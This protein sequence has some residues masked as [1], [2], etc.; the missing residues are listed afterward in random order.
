[1]RAIHERQ[2]TLL[3]GG[4]VAPGY[5]G[6]RTGSR[7]SKQASR[8]MA[9]VFAALFIGFATAATA[10][11][12]RHSGETERHFSAGANL[13]MPASSAAVAVNLW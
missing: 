11:T 3:G 9:V 8:R 1:M 7:I 4:C 10:I 13:S 6:R 2:V 12:V 5:R